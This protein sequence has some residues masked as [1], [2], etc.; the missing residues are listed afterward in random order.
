MPKGADLH[1]HLTGAAQTESQIDWGIED[2]LC[3]DDASITASGPPCG[4]GTVP[5]QVL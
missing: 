3:V 4:S 2:D 5:M 1:S